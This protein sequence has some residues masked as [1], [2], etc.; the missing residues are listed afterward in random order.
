MTTLVRGTTAKLADVKVGDQQKLHEINETV[1]TMVLFTRAAEA[2]PYGPERVEQVHGDWHTDPETAARHLYGAPVNFGLQTC[3]YIGTGFL[4]TFGPDVIKGGF[5]TYVKLANPVRHGDVLSINARAVDRRESPDGVSVTFDV[6]VENQ[7]QKVCAAARVRVR[8]GTI[9]IFGEP[10]EPLP[11]VERPEQTE[12]DP[13][14]DGVYE[15]EDAIVGDPGRPHVYMVTRDGIARYSEGIRSFS[16]LCHEVAVARQHGFSDVVGHPTYGLAA[17][18]NRRWEILKK[19]KLDTPHNHPT[20]PHATPFSRLDYTLYRPLV[21]GDLIVS[22]TRV[23]DKYIRKGRKYIAWGI[24]GKDSND[25][26][27]VDYI[28]T[29]FWARGKESDRT[30]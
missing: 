21:P 13:N 3:G 18:P 7:E 5:K 9:D 4:E 30:R 20:H 8:E 12:R 15:Y 2:D 23:A 1:A 10:L 27:V 6:L 26:V 29:C 25:Q 19:R 24:T 16:P 14:T 17:A 22:L 28:Y 11:E